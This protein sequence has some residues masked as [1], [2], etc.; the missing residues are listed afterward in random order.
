MTQNSPAE[1][2]G[3]AS[4]SHCCNTVTIS[5]SDDRKQVAPFPDNHDC[6]SIHN[7]LPKHLLV[8]AYQREKK[9]IAISDLHL[10]VILKNAILIYGIISRECKAEKLIKWKTPL[11]ILVALHLRR[12]CMFSHI[13][14]HHLRFVDRFLA[15]FIAGFIAASLTGALVTL[16]IGL[17]IMRS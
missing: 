6:D 9:L 13:C 1:T 3:I 7:A 14:D 5:I 12:Q 8:H 2:G 4:C 17:Q 16:T 15:G 11:C 10:W